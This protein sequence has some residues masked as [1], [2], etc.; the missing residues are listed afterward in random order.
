MD[1]SIRLAAGLVS[2]IAVL[3]EVTGSGSAMAQTTT[4]AP[5]PATREPQYEPTRV[6]FDDATVRVQEVTFMPGDQGP[7]V[8]RPYRVIRVLEGGTLERTY[9]DGKSE[10][11]EYR[12]GEVKVFDKDKPFVLRN[13][14]K[15]RVVLYVVALKDTGW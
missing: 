8:A 1:V 4:K 7:N 11:I 14:G 6:L 12:T 13:T 15:S 2:A 3:G 10:A 9:P 5:A